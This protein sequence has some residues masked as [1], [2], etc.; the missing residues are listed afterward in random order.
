M[1]NLKVAISEKW[2]KKMKSWEK[3]SEE[4]TN[5]PTQYP[6]MLRNNKSAPCATLFYCQVGTP[7]S[8]SEPGSCLWQKD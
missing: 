6:V 7:R 2:K 1:A 3:V 8:P 5:Q 4:P